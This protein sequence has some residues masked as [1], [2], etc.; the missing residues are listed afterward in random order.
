MELLTPLKQAEY[1][2]KTVSSVATV[3]VTSTWNAGPQGVVIW[4]DQAC[5]VEVGESVTATSSSTPIPPFTPVPFRVPAGTGSP[6]C[7]SVIRVA[8]D[9]ILY[10]KPIN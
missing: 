1:P 9:G 10:A 2:A 6:W 7:V 8:V 5:Y 3:S 4:C